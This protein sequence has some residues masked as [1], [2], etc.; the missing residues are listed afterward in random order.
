MRVLVGIA[1][2]GVANEQYLRKVVAA[3]ER[4]SYETDIVVFSNIP[5]DLGKRIRVIVGLPSGNPRSLGFAHRPFFIEHQDDYDIFVYSEDDIEILENQ[6]DFFIRQCE[7]LEF[8]EIPGLFPYELDRSGSLCYPEIHSTYHWDPGSVRRRGKYVFAE[9]T[10]LHSACYVLS[11]GQLQHCI[12]SGGYA[13]R[14]HSGEYN[15][16]CSAA[17]DPY[18]SCGLRKVY[19]ISHLDEISVHH[20]SDKYSTTNTRLRALPHTLLRAQ[21]DEMQRTDYSESK[22]WIASKTSWQLQDFCKE[23]YERPRRDVINLVSERDRSR[24]LSVGC[25]AGETERELS[26]LGN[27]VMAI[28]LDNVVGSCARANGIPTLSVNPLEALESLSSRQFNC[29]LIL[30]VLQHYPDPVALV[31]N[32]LKVLAPGGI[33]VC[34]VPNL[35]CMRAR[36]YLRGMDPALRDRRAFFSI[37]GLHYVT[38]RQVMRWFRHAGLKARTVLRRYGDKVTKVIQTWLPWGTQWL[39]LGNTI[40][41]VKRVTQR[42]EDGS[43]MAERRALEE[44]K[45]DATQ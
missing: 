9:F 25:G 45:R 27:E 41:F 36:K 26:E 43:M 13:S 5:R 38:R 4:M 8:D 34:S 29:I 20:L 24:I 33:V 19:C 3:Y 22:S 7:V 32:C 10:N 14:P 40:V 2:F 31:M 21:L 16:M 42:S 15:L 6:I 23:Y 44:S 35:S 18:T 11:R 39:A 1:S 12:R 17:S 28:P 37:H 30:D